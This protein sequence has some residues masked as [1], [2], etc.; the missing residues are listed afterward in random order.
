MFLRHAR[1][2][3]IFE[4]QMWRRCPHAKAALVSIV[5]FLQSPRRIKKKQLFVQM[6]SRVQLKNRKQE[7]AVLQNKLC[8]MVKQDGGNTVLGRPLY[9]FSLLCFTSRRTAALFWFFCSICVLSSSQR[10]RLQKILMIKVEQPPQTHTTTDTHTHTHTPVV[11]LSTP[12][13]HTQRHCS[14]VLVVSVYCA[15]FLILPLLLKVFLSMPPYF[16]LLVSSSLFVAVPSL[17]IT[18]LQ[19]KNPAAYPSFVSLLT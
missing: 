8:V 16:L 9:R 2:C 15:L 4:G 1:I 18:Y 19:H 7:R 10:P 11:P 5:R 17:H 14:H 12:Q 13:T 6:F 3:A